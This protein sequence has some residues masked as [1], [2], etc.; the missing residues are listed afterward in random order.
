MRNFGGGPSNLR[1]AMTSRWFWCTL[2]CEKHQLRLSIWMLK[3]KKA[4]NDDFSLW[5]NCNLIVLSD[6]NWPT[7]SRASC[8]YLW[9]VRK[10]HV[11]SICW[12]KSSYL[13]WQSG[14]FM[15][16]IKGQVLLFEILICFFRR[17]FLSALIFIVA[18]V[19]FPLE[20]VLW[21]RDDRNWN[22]PVT[23]MQLNILNRTVKITK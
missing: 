6:S 4:L 8:G 2:K 1:F 21:S 18:C 14:L 10:S 23:H 3:K 12:C 13:P 9:N 17:L 19:V 22:Q 7:G 5:H 11:I 16:M 20:I 15:Y